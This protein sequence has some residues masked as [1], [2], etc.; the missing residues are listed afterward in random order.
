MLVCA[1]SVAL[2]RSRSSAPL[3]VHLPDQD[4]AF[5]PPSNVSP[6]S[7]SQSS[8]SWVHGEF[9]VVST[10]HLRGEGSL[11]SDATSAELQGSLAGA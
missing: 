11:G 3:H 4:S 8:D 1:I 10:T 2:W 6:V 9:V 7:L 5:M